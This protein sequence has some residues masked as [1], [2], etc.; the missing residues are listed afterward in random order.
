[1]W[2][3]SDCRKEK[4]EKY[5][6]AEDQF[7]IL[8]VGN[9]LVQEVTEDFLKTIYAMLEENPKTVLAVIGNCEALEKG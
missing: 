9:R 2:E 1:M 7:V 6:I 4:K 3:N 8:L 5:G